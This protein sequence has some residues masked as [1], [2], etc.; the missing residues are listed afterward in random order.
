MPSC[1]CSCS[2]QGALLYIYVQKKRGCTRKILTVAFGSYFLWPY[3][4]DMIY[5]KLYIFVYKNH[6][7]LLNHDLYYLWYSSYTYQEKTTQVL[8]IIS[9]CRWL[10]PG[11][12]TSW[13]TYVRSARPNTICQPT[14]C[15][16]R[17]MS[18]PKTNERLRK[19]RSILCRSLLFIV[20]E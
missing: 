10:Q 7:I 8:I 9:R 2:I 19:G 1:V 14:L 18:Q 12:A 17:K 4:N 6:F 15:G 3:R 16:R 11:M 5:I 13:K 20:E